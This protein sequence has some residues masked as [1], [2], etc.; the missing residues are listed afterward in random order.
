MFYRNL[1]LKLGIN[2]NQINQGV[3]FRSIY[4]CILL[5][6]TSDLTKPIILIFN[7]DGIFEFSFSFSDVWAL[8]DSLDLEDEIRISHYTEKGEIW[9]LTSKSK[10]FHININENKIM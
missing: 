7:Y 9:F 5:K 3:Y 10:Y 2:I 6:K 8:T 4:H 1:L